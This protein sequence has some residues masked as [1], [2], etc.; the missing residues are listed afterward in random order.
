LIGGETAEHPGLLDPDEYDIA[1]AVTG[2]VDEDSVLGP[3]LVREGDVLIAM[4]SSGL[5]SN[6][7]SLARHVLLQHSRLRLDA[8][9]DELGRTLGEELLEPTRIYARDCLALAA[10]VEVHAMS[11]IT[12]GGFAA[13]LARVLPP[14][15]EAVVQRGTWSPQPVFDLIAARGKVEREEMERTFNMGVGM[16][17]VLAAPD[18]DRALAVLTA[19]HVPA[20]VCGEVRAS[21]DEASARLEGEYAGA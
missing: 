16:V 20:W 21:H 13:N 6:G 12:G 8:D 1:G 19:R 7:Y 15:V 18:V 11:H 14:G 3:D 10:E 9:L 2:M 17:A 5:H 4:G